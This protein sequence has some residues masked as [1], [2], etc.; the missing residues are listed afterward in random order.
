MTDN[1]DSLEISP[2]LAGLILDVVREQGVSDSLVLRD[3]GI[4]PVLLALGDTYLSYRQ[5]LALIKNSLALSR[6]PEL[7]VL[8]G[9]QENIST[10]GVLGYAIMSSA[11]Y[12]EAFSVGLKFHRTAPGMMSMSAREE[13]DRVMIRLDSPCPLGSALPFCVEEMIMGIITVSS[14]V[15]QRRIHPVEICLSYPKPTYSHRYRKFFRCPIHY[16]QPINAFWIATPDD[17]PLPHSDP[18]TARINLRL[19]E[20]ML[21]RHSREENLILDVRRILL[22]TPGQFPDMEAVAAELAMSS[23]TLRRKLGELGGNFSSVIDDVRRQLAVDYLQNSSLTLDDIST[24]L[25]YTE[26]TNF[27]RAF[28]QWTGHPPSHYRPA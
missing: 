22:R 1:L 7:G 24:L 14:M 6:T 4:R 17:T 16:G 9:S 12:R 3:T 11:T 10:W 5:M 20:Q 2:Q 28:K 18:I 13:G 15:V 21:A 23:R 8:V 19:V 25:G 27:R 26:P